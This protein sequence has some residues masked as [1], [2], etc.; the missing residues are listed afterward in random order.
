MKKSTNVS[1]T[2][3]Y[4]LV[5]IVSDI[6]KSVPLKKIGQGDVAQFLQWH[7]SMAYVEIYKCLPHIF[8]L[9]LTVSEILQEK[10][11]LRKWVK[12]TENNFCNDTIS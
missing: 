9:A 10:N 8:A 3:S 12:V 4:V 5:F 11:Y 2:F 6:T 1:H 7:Y